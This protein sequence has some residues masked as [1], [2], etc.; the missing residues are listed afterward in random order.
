MAFMANY[1]LLE[2]NSTSSNGKRIQQQ[3]WLGGGIKLPTGQFNIDATDPALV[4]LANTQTGSASAD[5]MLNGLYNL[6][7]NKWGLQYQPF[8]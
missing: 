6:Q 8:L 2:K 1:K 3:V 5:Y 4:S 7:I